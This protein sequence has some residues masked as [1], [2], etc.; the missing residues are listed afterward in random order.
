[1][2]SF[3]YRAWVDANPAVSH[4]RPEHDRFQVYLGSLSGVGTPA[5]R[6]RD[7]LGDAARRYYA[8]RFSDNVS[9]PE[10][11]C[12][13]IEDHFGVSAHLEEFVG[14]W[15]DIPES[16]L[17]RLQDPG[18]GMAALGGKLG[19][20]TQLGRRSWLQQGKFRVVLGPLTRHQFNRVAPGGSDLRALTALVCG[21]AGSDLR[22]DL[23][24]RL[25][26]DA[27]P[28]LQLGTAKL[29]QTAWLWSTGDEPQDD[30]ICDPLG[31]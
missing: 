17:W 7:E 5:L 8:G 19:L 20:S 2:F 26:P 25:R 12:A 9:N 15:V 31:A 3:F 28:G 21:Y 13:L 6:D 14:E 10:G 24:L 30:V 23:R 1:M 11:L 29:G 4:D 22:W 18:L 16:S 27:V